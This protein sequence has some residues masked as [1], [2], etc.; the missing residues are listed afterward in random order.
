MCTKPKIDDWKHSFCK[1]FILS[2][3]FKY[4]NSSVFRS[5]WSE[6]GHKLWHSGLK[7]ARVAGKVSRH[8]P[9]MVRT[10]HCH[11]HNEKNSKLHLFITSPLSTTNQ[12]C[13]E[14]YDNKTAKDT[15]NCYRHNVTFRGVVRI[16]SMCTFL[17]CKLNLKVKKFNNFKLQNKMQPTC[18]LYNLSARVI[19]YI[20]HLISVLAAEG[21]G[22]GEGRYM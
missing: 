22:F 17:S 9:C 15:S 11:Q 3:C 7:L 6:S 14:K 2:M 16:S 4:Q 5:L 20:C 10:S 21:K 19:S 8:G 1:S 13:N 12:I 18:S